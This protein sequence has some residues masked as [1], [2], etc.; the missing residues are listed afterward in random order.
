[1]DA[2][3]SVTVKARV[4]N[5]GEWDADEIVQLYV[6][7]RVGS[8]TRPVKELKGYKRLHLKRVRRLM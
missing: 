8:I 1:M 2:A 6:R 4:T 3:G 5:S 7:D